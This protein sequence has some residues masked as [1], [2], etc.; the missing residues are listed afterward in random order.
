MGPHILLPG[1]K[2][3]QLHLYATPQTATVFKRRC[4][5]ETWMCLW[6]LSLLFC[7]LIKDALPHMACARACTSMSHR[8][9]HH[10]A[11]S[12]TSDGRVRV[13]Y[14]LMCGPW[15][16]RQSRLAKSTKGCGNKAQIGYFD[17]TRWTG[18]KRCMSGACSVLCIIS[19]PCLSGTSGNVVSG[20]SYGLS[21]DS[22][23]RQ[24]DA[25]QP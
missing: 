17:T 15:R 10:T 13:S 12:F 4:V 14:V 8:F 2:R 23:L 19:W 20:M 1:F 7:F 11:C 16:Q 24:L 21:T 18:T 9:H 6:A 22:R 25:L 5:V 3:L